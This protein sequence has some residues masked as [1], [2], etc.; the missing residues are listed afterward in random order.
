MFENP[1]LI[2]RICRR[3]ESQESTASSLRIYRSRSCPIRCSYLED[4]P[5][6]EQFETSLFVTFPDSKLVP[7]VPD[8]IFIEELQF[9]AVSSSIDRHLQSSIQFEL[10]S[11]R[12]P[13]PFTVTAASTS[14]SSFPL[15]SQPKITPPQTPPSTPPST[16]QIPIVTP[17]PPVVRSP[18][19]AMANKYTPLVFPANLGAM[20]Q[21]YQSKITPFDGTGTYTAQQ[22]TKKMTDYFKIYEIDTDDVRM[23]IFVQSLTGEVRTWFRALR[24]KQHRQLRNLL[25]IILESLGEKERSSADLIQV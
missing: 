10:T 7:L 3:Q 19:A 15:I 17:T 12:T 20:P 23:R 11:E 22:H 2:P 24:E 25:Y 8:P 13:N 14:S 16:T 18:P 4:E 6:D 21:D 1:N 9:E 5:F